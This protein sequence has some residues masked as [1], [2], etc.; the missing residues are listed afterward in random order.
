[1]RKLFFAGIV[2]LA[3]FLSISN[4][5]AANSTNVTINQVVNASSVVKSYVETNHTLP[6]TVNVSGNQVNMQQFLE[7][8]T[9]AVSNI[10]NKS[11]ATIALKDYGNATAPSENITSRNINKTEYLDMANRVKS[12]MDSNGRSPN[13]ATQ[14]STGDTIGFESMVYMYSKI[15][16]YYKTNNVLPNYVAVNPWVNISTSNSANVI[17]STSYGYVEKKVYGNQSSNQT[18]VIIVGVHPEE[19]GMHVAVANALASKSATLSKR[20]VLYYVHVTQDASDY[21]KGR[22]NGQLLAQ[23]FVVPDVP[24]EH[25]ML[26]VDIHENHGA[27]SGYAYYRFL[28]P[29]SSTAITKTYANE[30]IS[31]MPFLVTYT[32]P[33]PTS[34]Q[35]VTVPIANEG[36]P[37]IIYETYLSDSTA[38]KNSDANAFISALD[39]KVGNVSSGTTTSDNIAP[40]ITSSSPKNGATGFSTTATITIK[41]SENI[42]TSVNWSKIYI[43]NLNTG[44]TAV[45]S[46]SINGNTLSIKMAL[47]RYSYNQY[48]IYIPASSVKDS[49]GNNLVTGYTLKFKTGAQ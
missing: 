26:A 45:I 39:S 29:I 13:Y 18:I 35:Y 21:N 20:Y 44:K 43:K 38:K 30:I 3:L 34:T 24:K 5:S 12:Y 32:P 14:T 31:A 15:L 42:K 1:M 41:F 16:N 8:S 46:K 22:M 49:A 23:Q 19:S 28:Y 47:K 36:I 27:D 2:V 17:G 37:A 7:L 33:N 48:Q 10:N 11:N 4:V 9:T 25:P 6:S 40:K